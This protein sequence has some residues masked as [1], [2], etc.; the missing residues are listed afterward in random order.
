MKIYFFREII[1][2]EHTL[3]PDPDCMKI[4]GKIGC[5]AKVIKRKIAKVIIHQ[6]YNSSRKTSPY[7]IALIRLDEAVPLSYEDPAKSSVSPVCL[8]WASNDPGKDYVPGDLATIT[9]WGRIT[10]NAQI[11]FANYLK[12]KILNLKLLKLQVPLLDGNECLKDPIFKDVLSDI[13]VCAGAERGM[14]TIFE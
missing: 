12:F 3:G 9:G 2:G 1:L 10:N 4:Q 11:S 5:V 6:N 14:N 13:Q 7:D 8:P